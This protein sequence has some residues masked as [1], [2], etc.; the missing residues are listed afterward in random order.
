MQ[1]PHCGM[2][3][4]FPIC[5]GTLRN[6]FQVFISVVTSYWHWEFMYGLHLKI[7]NYEVK[8]ICVSIIVVAGCFKHSSE[9]NSCTFVDYLTSS[10]VETLSITIQSL[11]YY[12]EIVA[13]LQKNA[14]CGL[15]L[16]LPPTKHRCQSC[17]LFPD[18]NICS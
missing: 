3:L 5:N 15:N 16:C 10:F 2:Q 17:V 9:G 14:L 4:N 1:H 6:P 7:F 18:K 12:Y 13:A 11:F 8:H